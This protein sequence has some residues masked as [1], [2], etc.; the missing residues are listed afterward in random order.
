MGWILNI[1]NLLYLSRQKHLKKSW[2]W[3]L[4]KKLQKIAYKMIYAQTKDF[5]GVRT[6][7]EVVFFCK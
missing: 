6:Y 1:C 2:W 7:K 4:K 5:S 3:T